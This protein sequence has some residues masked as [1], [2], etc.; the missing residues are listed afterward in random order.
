MQNQTFSIATAFAAVTEFEVVAQPDG[1]QLELIEMREA[2]ISHQ[3]PPPAQKQFEKYGVFP[4]LT[5]KWI[6]LKT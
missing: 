3:L 1:R 4:P 6:F 5:I 2:P